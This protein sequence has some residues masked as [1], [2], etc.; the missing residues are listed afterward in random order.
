MPHP[1]AGRSY[2]PT[3]WRFAQRTCYVYSLNPHGSEGG[4]VLK[5][6]AQF[7]IGYEQL[8]DAEGRV[9]DELPP[10]ANDAGQMRRMYEMMVLC[11]LFDTKAIN[12]QRTGRLGTYA[13]CTGH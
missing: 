13:P 4:S 3:H 5:T 7:A 6:V 11:R 9:C 8:L 2:P 1:T 12:L 10:F